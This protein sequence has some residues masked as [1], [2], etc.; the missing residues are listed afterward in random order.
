MHYKHTKA[1]YMTKSSST[2]FPLHASGK[3]TTDFGTR[4]K[5]M[6]RRRRIHIAL[7]QPTTVDWVKKLRKNH[8]ITQT[9]EGWNIH[10]NQSAYATN[11]LN[12]W[13]TERQQQLQK[14]QN[15]I[16]HEK[17]HP[18]T[19]GQEKQKPYKTT[20]QTTHMG[21]GGYA[22][23]KKIIQLKQQKAPITQRNNMETKEHETIA[24][25]ILQYPTTCT[26]HEAKVS[27][28]R[29]QTCRMDFATKQGRNQHQRLAKKCKSTNRRENATPK[30]LPTLFP[31]NNCAE[32]SKT[33]HRLGKH[34]LYHCHGQNTMNELNQIQPHLKTHR[35]RMIHK[36]VPKT[37]I[38]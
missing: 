17:Q 10:R 11:T 15:I 25:I 12:E 13:N 36:G 29:C 20:Y 38:T 7:K 2:V 30:Q 4:K 18:P 37:E 34:L 19:S 21:M 28:H 5:Q 24:Q 22:A 31:I 26:V 35:N 1:Q 6:P 32:I 27:Q 14:I 3:Y 16:E 33:H 9:P 23:L 8:M